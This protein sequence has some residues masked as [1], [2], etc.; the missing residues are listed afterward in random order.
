MSLA[1]FLSA[2]LTTGTQAAAA[3]QQGIGARKRTETADLL[4]QIKLARQQNEDAMTKQ[5]RDAQ[6]KNYES[7]A[8]QREEPSA[9]RE[10]PYIPEG[11][12][13]PDGKGGY[14]IPAPRRFAPKAASSGSGGNGAAL[15][16]PDESRHKA[17]ISGWAAATIKAG[18]ANPDRLV[19]AALAMNP[20]VNPQIVSAAVYEALLKSEEA[21]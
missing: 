11:A 5:L 17:R 8:T 21:P 12:A 13:V 20:G 10:A 6:I 18:E 2:G 14:T 16:S 4:D 9:P 7:M 19:A 1:N 3:H 15:G